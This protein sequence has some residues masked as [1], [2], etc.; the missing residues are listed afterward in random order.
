MNLV[1]FVNGGPMDCESLSST[2]TLQS[3]L[4]QSGKFSML[5]DGSKQTKRRVSAK[6]LLVPA[7]RIMAGTRGNKDENL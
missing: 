3:T 1:V 6:H 7:S 5:L 4:S 2:T